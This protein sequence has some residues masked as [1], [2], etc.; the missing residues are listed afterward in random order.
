[1]DSPAGRS[2]Y[3]E[4]EDFGFSAFAFASLT[5][6]PVA[7][8]FR[9]NWLHQSP[10]PVVRAVYKIHLSQVLLDPY[11]RHRFA[12][13]SFAICSMVL[14]LTRA[15][16]RSMRTPTTRCGPLKGTR[17]YFFMA[18]YERAHSQTT[19]TIQT[20]VQSRNARSAA[21]F[22]GHTTLLY[23]ARVCTPSYELQT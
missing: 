13:C 23:A 18:R 1:M 17:S 12:F 8:L 20:C 21:L 7:G 14:I 2:K 5:C 9:Q 19:S 10:I 15:G 22:G 11:L 3:R 4:S 16:E 6:L